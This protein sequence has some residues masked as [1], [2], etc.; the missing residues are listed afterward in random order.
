ME[1]IR[2]GPLISFISAIKNGKNREGNQDKTLFW[3]GGESIFS[4]VFR[5]GSLLT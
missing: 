1:E 3:L 4:K 5:D 2:A